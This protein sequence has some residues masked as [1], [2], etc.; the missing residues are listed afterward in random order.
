MSGFLCPDNGKTYDIF[1]RGGAQQMA[2]QLEVPFL[3]DIPITIS[4]RSESDE[5]RLRAALDDPMT[6]KPMENIARALTRSLAARAA[7]QGAASM[8]LPVLG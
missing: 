4:V 6:S 3:G 2:A 7:D 5:G 1:G 8:P